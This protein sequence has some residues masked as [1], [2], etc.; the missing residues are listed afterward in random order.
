MGVEGVYIC[1]CLSVS[2]AE[3]QGEGVQDRD[4][5]RSQAGRGRTG[6]TV[7]IKS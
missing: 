6:E 1:V 2:E 5:G 3:R 7:G 4:G